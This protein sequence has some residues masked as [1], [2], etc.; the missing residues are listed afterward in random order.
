MR[1][2]HARGGRRRSVKAYIEDIRELTDS[3]EMLE[4]RPHRFMAWFVYL[5]IL[6][7]ASTLIWSYFGEI[8][9]YV[10]A[11]GIV[12]PGGSIG[13]VRNATS[14]NI[15]ELRI[16]DGM[17]VGKG[18]VLFVVETKELLL[19]KAES[20][21]VL[22]KLKADGANLETLRR[23]VRAGKNLFD[24]DDADASDYYNQ[25]EK[26]MA[27]RRTALEQAEN[28]ALDQQKLKDD[29]AASVRSAESA[30]KNAAS[31][32]R[33]AEYLL[34]R[35]NLLLRGVEREED[36]FMTTANIL[37]IGA[38]HESELNDLYR[39]RYENYVL[40]RS[41]LLLALEQARREAET[42]ETL[43]AADSVALNELEAA[44]RGVEL[45][46]LEYDKYGSDFLLSL[47]D[48]IRQTEQNVREHKNTIAQIDMTIDSYIEY[49]K[50]QDVGLMLGKMQLDTQVQA[51]SAITSNQSAIEQLEGEIKAIELSI[52]A[53]TV[54]APISGFVSMDAELNEG[55]MLGAGAEVASIVPDDGTDYRIQL[56]ILNE[57]IA[58]IQGAQKIRYHFSALPY[59]EYG[60]ASGEILRIGTDA[61]AANGVSYYLVDASLNELELTGYGGTAG[62]IKVGMACEAQVITQSKKILWWLLEKI[63]LRD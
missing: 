51:D 58:S 20:A 52:E 55:E 22:D 13:A 46:Q 11:S 7:V 41:G 36:V 16:E 61:R 28:A 29:M 21:R 17:R 50:S 8:D 33:E 45:A 47:R 37:S 57:D 26:Y 44:R 35:Q 32:L 1:H 2:R 56:M 53:A 54:T 19:Q 48:S 49:E 34:G 3:R 62:R 59:R 5:L 38:E 60:E 9:E 30:R 6:L 40:T 4:A 10:K 18:D 12:R 15:A 43:Y 42:A 31:D 27:D 14:G 24:P 23:S 25:F 63:N 39:G